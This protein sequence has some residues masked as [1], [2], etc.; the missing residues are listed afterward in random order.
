MLFD[1]RMIPLMIFGMA[2]LVKVLMGCQQDCITKVNIITLSC[3][4]FRLS[5]FQFAVNAAETHWAGR[6]RSLKQIKGC[7][8]KFYLKRSATSQVFFVKSSLVT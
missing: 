8:I 3:T 6:E 4:Y 7:V 5:I 2:N 1:F